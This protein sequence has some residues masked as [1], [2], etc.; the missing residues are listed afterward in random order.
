MEPDVEGGV[1]NVEL[2]PVDNL[3]E[4]YQY[5]RNLQYNQPRQPKR[6]DIVKYFDFNFNGWLRVRVVSQHKKSSK[7]AGSVN[8]TF[9]DIDR[10]PDGK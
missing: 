6:G 3:P 7:Y 4:E 8:C 10:E 1:L 2:A 9:L 5:L